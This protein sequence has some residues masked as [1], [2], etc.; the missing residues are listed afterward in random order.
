MAVSI[1]EAWNDR[2]P[3][4]GPVISAKKIF[5]APPEEVPEQNN[6][7]HNEHTAAVQEK[8]DILI[9]E[10]RQ[11]RMEE[12]RRCTVYLIIGG[13][14]FALLFVYIDRLQHQI[15]VAHTNRPDSYMFPEPTYTSTRLPP[16]W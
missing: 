14:L 7:V 3:S 13:L 10:F 9:N 8:L 12:S 2:P 4:P 16:R 5:D 6:N 15:K 11:M 1:S